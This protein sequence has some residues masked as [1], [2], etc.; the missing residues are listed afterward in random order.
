VGARASRAGLVASI[1][2]LRD[3]PTGVLPPLSFARGQHGG[4]RASV[5]IRPDRGYGIVVLG[6]WRSPR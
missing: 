4:N 3:F 2:T 5:V 6:G 1:E